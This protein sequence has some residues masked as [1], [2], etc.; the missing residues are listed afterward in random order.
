MKKTLSFLLMILLTCGICSCSSNSEIDYE[1][2][3]NA[4]SMDFGGYEFIIMQENFVESGKERTVYLNTDMIKRR[5]AEIS[6]DW[7]CTVKIETD[8][9]E[10]LGSIFPTLMAGGYIGEI[11]YNSEPSELASIGAFHPLNDLKDYIDYTNTEKYGPYGILEQGIYN[12]VLYTVSPAAWPGKQTA[13]GA[14][15]I[16]AVNENLISRYGLDDPRDLLENGQWTWDTFES[17]LPK[18]TFTDNSGNKIKAANI[19][20]S[21]LD[22][23]M[24]NGADYTKVINGTPFP[25]LDSPEVTET[26]DW[27]ADIFTKYS[28]CITF[29]DHDTMV[30]KF[31]N[32]QLMLTQT[33]IDQVIEFVN[34]IEEPGI[35]PMPCGPSGTYG[36]WVSTYSEKTCFGLLVNAK[37]PIASARIID[38]LCEPWENYETPSAL[39]DYYRS[40]FSDSRDIDLIFSVFENSRW[41]YLPKAD[42][43]DFFE[44]ATKETQIGRASQGII[45]MFIE[46]V[47]SS[48]K[49]Y[50]IPNYEFISQ[51]EAENLEN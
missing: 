33:S 14:N 27:C 47:N 9:R 7:N 1:M 2:G 35:V 21:I 42:I 40:F 29:D 16:F 43:Y 18:Y 3:S 19:T 34:Y 15:G 38:R 49:E 48:V 20:W 46:K 24:T 25:S 50:V 51:Y 45:S 41:N 22:L 8:E 23:A 4:L 13:I 31:I 37:K 30:P 32:G 28:H 12:G 10:N 11:V 36:K 39:K 26:L 5:L 6:E 44:S 17:L